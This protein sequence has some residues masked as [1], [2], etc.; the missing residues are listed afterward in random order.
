MPWLCAN[1]ALELSKILGNNGQ[2]SREFENRVRRHNE[3][4][5]SY[6]T[7]ADPPSNPMYKFLLKSCAV[8]SGAT[9]T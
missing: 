6:Y 2:L 9:H 7:Q 3:L 5:P 1:C 8:V 4:L